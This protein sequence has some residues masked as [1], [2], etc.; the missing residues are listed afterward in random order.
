MTDALLLSLFGFGHWNNGERSGM[1]ATD[2]DLDVKPP[3]APRQT[4]CTDDPWLKLTET[5]RLKLA[6]A[7]FADILRLCGEVTAKIDAAAAQVR[8]LRRLR[9]E[10]S[11][12]ADVAARVWLRKVER[13]WGTLSTI[14]RQCVALRGFYVEMSHGSGCRGGDEAAVD[15]LATALQRIH[16]DLS[17]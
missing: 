13:D 1:E 15:E 3:P 10:G 17:Q 5:Q 9:A 2:M 7:Q 8:E 12:D 11:F 4:G 6:K 14:A 16:I